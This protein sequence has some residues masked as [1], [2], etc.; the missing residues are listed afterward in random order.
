MG[1]GLASEWAQTPV[2][3]AGITGDSLTICG[4]ASKFLFDRKNAL[5]G[6]A[7]D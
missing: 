5:L 3:D 1:S 7:E 4:T 2:L 6:F